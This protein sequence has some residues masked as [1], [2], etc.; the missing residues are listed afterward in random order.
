MKRLFIALT[1]AVL[2]SACAHNGA[3]PEPAKPVSADEAH[4]EIL[5]AETARSKAASVGY[6]WR[7][8]G[9]FI[10]QARKLM[11]EGKNADAFKLAKKAKQQGELAYTQ[12]ELENGRK[13]ATP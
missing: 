8:T 3:P 2:L 12:W 7:D 13:L 5:A 10:D 11:K 6:E 4:A 1:S 9:K